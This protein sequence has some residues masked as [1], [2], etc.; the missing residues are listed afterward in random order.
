MR[1]APFDGELLGVRVLHVHRDVAAIFIDRRQPPLTGRADGGR[2]ADQMRQIGVEPHIHARVHRRLDQQIEVAVVIAG[3]HGL[4]AGR[5]DLLDVGG[6][7]LHL[8][9]GHQLIADDFDVRAVFLQIFQRVVAHRLAEQVILVQQVH[10]LDVGGQRFDPGRRAHFH[11][12]GEA[13]LPEVAFLI[14]QLGRERAAVQIDHPV[15]GIARVM[16]R[17]AI[18]QRGADVRPGALHDEGNVLIGDVLQRDQRLG[19]LQLVVERYDLEL[20]AEGAA[21]GVETVEQNLEDF[22]K[23]IAARGE[24]TGERVDIGDLDRLGR[25][26]RLGR[27]SARGQNGGRGGTAK[28]SHHAVPS[29]GSGRIVAPGLR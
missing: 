10:F 1:L 20:T 29:L 13:E 18:D 2:A 17:H 23:F 26:G 28:R 24:G 14:G 15:V 3:D 4:R 9:E 16:F 21:L 8:A 27:E 25:G 11:A 6:E 12:A 22:Q 19:R 7:V 5:L